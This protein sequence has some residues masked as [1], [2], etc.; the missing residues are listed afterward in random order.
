MIE[1]TYAPV[2]NSERRVKLVE[3]PLNSGVNSDI[4]KINYTRHVKSDSH[5]RAVYHGNAEPCQ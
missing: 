3:F 4:N 1:F 2:L 5:G